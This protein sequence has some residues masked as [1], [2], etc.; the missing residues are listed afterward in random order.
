MQ[1]D[2]PYEALFQLFFQSKKASKTT[3]LATNKILFPI[4][5]TDIYEK[6]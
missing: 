5:S 3:V 4:K 2:E 1:W 6:I